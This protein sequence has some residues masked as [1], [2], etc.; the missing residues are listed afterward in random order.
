[1]SI[2]FIVLAFAVLSRMQE[3]EFHRA[4]VKQKDSLQGST[5]TNYDNAIYGHHDNSSMLS[6]GSG[7][8]IFVEDTMTA[9]K[10]MEYAIA[11]QE[12]LLNRDDLLMECEVKVNISAVLLNVL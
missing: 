9:L 8:M 12:D 4:F 6:A 1:M 11:Q 3:Y 2:G 7:M 10:A 5:Y